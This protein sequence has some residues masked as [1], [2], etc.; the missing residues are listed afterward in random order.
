[1]L[2]TKSFERDFQTLNT[3]CM[4]PRDFDPKTYHLLYND[5]NNYSLTKSEHGPP[6]PN[7]SNKHVMTSK[8]SRAVFPRSNPSL[9]IEYVLHLQYNKALL[10]FILCLFSRPQKVAL[11]SNATT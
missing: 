7:S 6:W 8:D 4:S 9:R 3:V 2:C 10:T 5:R 1:M 11:L